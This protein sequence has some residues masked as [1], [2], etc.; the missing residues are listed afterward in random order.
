MDRE[1]ECGDLN[2]VAKCFTA[3]WRDKKDCHSHN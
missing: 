1:Q 2:L 3:E